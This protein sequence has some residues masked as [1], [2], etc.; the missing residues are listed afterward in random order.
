MLC[1]AAKEL[2]GLGKHSICGKR[3]RPGDVGPAVNWVCIEDAGLPR[4]F[5][6]ISHIATWDRDETESL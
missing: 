2:R 5:S 3:L 1:A 6:I 4:L